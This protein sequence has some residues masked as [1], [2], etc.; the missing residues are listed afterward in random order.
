MKM[1]NPPPIQRQDDEN[2]QRLKCNGRDGQEIDGP[3]LVE[4]IPDEGL[5]VLIGSSPPPY[6][7]L[8]HRRYGQEMSQH[9]Q[10]TLDMRRSPVRIIK[11]DPVDQFDHPDRDF[12]S[13]H[14]FGPTLSFPVLTPQVPMPGNNCLGLDQP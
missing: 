10:F 3:D 9:H 5:P 1:N 11:R 8:R 2:V 12:R 14:L 4:M 6:H 13:S 7:V